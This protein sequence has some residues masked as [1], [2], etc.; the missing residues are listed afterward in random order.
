M[1]FPFPIHLIAKANQSRTKRRRDSGTLQN[2]GQ[3][4]NECVSI[5]EEWVGAVV[6]EDW[7]PISTDGIVL[8]VTAL[9]SQD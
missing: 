8:D 2:M 1:S 7:L 9:E 3:D 4:M 6:A 5:L